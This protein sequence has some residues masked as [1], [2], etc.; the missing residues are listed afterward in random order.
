MTFQCAFIP[1]PMLGGVAL[2]HTEFKSGRINKTFKYKLC[3]V[4]FYKI[5]IKNVII[6]YVNLYLSNFDFLSILS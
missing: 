6:I 2:T 4:I 1:Y 5:L 3:G